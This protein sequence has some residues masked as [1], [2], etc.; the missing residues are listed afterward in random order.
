MGTRIE[1]FAPSDALAAAAARVAEVFGT[2]EEALS[3][4]RPGSELMRLNGAAGAPFAASDL[5]YR[6][7]ERAI[8]WAERTGGA[9]DPLLGGQ[10]AE[11]GYDR[12]FAEIG[13]GGQLPPMTGEVS[14]GGAWRR[15]HLEPRLRRIVLPR[16]AALDLGGIAKGMAVDA[17]LEALAA[18][19]VEDALVSAGGDLAVRG[20]APG[21]G[22]WPV[23]VAG[24]GPTALLLHRGALA[25]SGTA[26][27]HWLQ[28]AERRHHLLDPAAGQPVRETLG[29]A[30]VIAA[31]CG[32]ADAAA[33]AVFVRGAAG[34]AA[35]LESLGLAGILV[36]TDGG[37]VRVGAW[38]EGAG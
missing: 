30:S 5:L 22:P 15:V 25:T 2:W 6:A 8:G 12:T 29:S 32:D 9:F 37:V 33:T 17:A 34:G 13:T 24:L 27:R 38:P 19:G 11:L 28:G 16:G 31:S 26:R 7:A 18:M 21:G 23:G 10:L 1:V 36:R 14:R 20:A 3:R 35:L 4:F